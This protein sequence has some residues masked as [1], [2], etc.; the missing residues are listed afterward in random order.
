MK[1]YLLALD[2]G[3]QSV[4]AALLGA[5]LQILGIQQ[6]SHPL[7]SPQPGWAQQNPEIWWEG[8]SAATR[9][10]LAESSIDPRSI[11][12]VG[13]CGQM[14]GPVGVDESGA[15]TTPM[16]QL[17]CDKRCR[18][19]C[20]QVR[21]RPDSRALEARAANPIN[22]AWVGFKVLW[23]KRNDAASYQRTRCFL[24]PKDF[25]NYRLTDV[26]A[27]DPSEAS[28]SFLWDARD[29]RYSPE[30]AEALELDLDKFAPAVAADA[31]I[32][33]V[34]DVAGKQTGIPAGTPVVAGGGDLLVAMLGFGVVGEGIAAHVAGSADDFAT[35]CPHP[36][37]HPAI[38]NLHHVV[39]GWVPFT[40]LDC[41]GLGMKWWKEWMEAAGGTSHSF[42]WLADLASQAEPGSEGLLFLPYLLGER[43]HENMYAR[44][45]FSGVTLAHTPAHFARAILEGVAFAHG[46]SARLF[47]DLGVSIERILCAGGGSRNDLW[48]QIKADVFEKPVEI[49]EEPEAGLK[50]AALLAA[51]GAGMIGDPAAAARACGGATRCILPDLA[52]V[53]AYRQGMAEFERLYAHMLGFWAAP[54]GR[55]D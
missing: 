20:E 40:I 31:V 4:R 5:D 42:E 18:L 47:A 9:R 45:L 23:I 53:R 7:D 34:S 6:V 24:V 50:G 19:E 2:I 28:G 33:T 10:L 1:R 36:L 14:H 22:P 11:A 27:T 17:W 43:R 48:N 12:A 26:L 39:D 32:G 8:L 16:V 30:Q 38:Q 15:V 25:I 41:G 37:L 44:G 54:A 55:E 51:S 35:H 3:T 21:R 29:E 46:R 49:S 13:A 52:H